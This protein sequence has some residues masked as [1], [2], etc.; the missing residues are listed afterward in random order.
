MRRYLVKYLKQLV[1]LELVLARLQ[2][3]VEG[4]QK[5]F[6]LVRSLP[7]HSV[8]VARTVKVGS[9]HHVAE[10]LH[11]Y[12][13]IVFVPDDLPEQVEALDVGRPALRIQLK[14][15]LTSS[16]SRAASRHLVQQGLE[17]HEVDAA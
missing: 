6:L 3:G 12:R 15:S 13:V 10:H 16:P 4:E 11:V 14:T 5:I 1:D 8:E 9:L 2:V 17:L 7:H